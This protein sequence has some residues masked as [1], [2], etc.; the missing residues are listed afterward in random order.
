MWKFWNRV[1]NTVGITTRTIWTAWRTTIDTT[2]AAL[3]VVLDPVIGIGQTAKDIKQA[4]HSSFTEW[5]R[6][7]KLRKVPASLIS[8]PFMLAEWVAETLRWTW[9]NACSSVRD[10]IWNTLTN[11]W[12]AIK[13]IWKSDDPKLF[14]IEKTTYKPLSPKN[15]LAN[16]FK[17]P[18]DRSPEIILSQNLREKDKYL[19]WKEDNLKKKEEMLQK[20]TK[21]QEEYFKKSRNEFTEH[22]KAYEDKIDKTLNDIKTK[23]VSWKKEKEELI[24]NLK[25]KDEEIKK[26]KAEK[27]KNTPEVKP[28]STETGTPA[29][30]TK[31][32]WWEPALAA[33]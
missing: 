5:P 15:W 25:R 26:I 31:T 17:P 11:E 9:V 8:T 19:K 13:M 21:D 23:E 4:I 30:E 6:Y 10:I 24:A 16:L 33:A 22:Q 14:S 7:R 1:R 32:P 27:S 28:K 12:N 18:K 3:N 20:K 2:K 29:P